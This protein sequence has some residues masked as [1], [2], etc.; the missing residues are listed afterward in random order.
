M[1]KKLNIVIPGELLNL[2][3][4][5]KFGFRTDGEFILVKA[6]KEERFTTSLT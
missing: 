5:I 6:N 4:N 3:T 1:K 2:V